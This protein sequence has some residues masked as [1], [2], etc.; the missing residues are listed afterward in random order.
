MC[1]VPKRRG[2][3]ENGHHL[4]TGVRLP[5]V[6]S[7]RSPA[8]AINPFIT[9]Q[10][11]LNQLA[12]TAIRSRSSKSLFYCAQRGRNENVPSASRDTEEEHIAYRREVYRLED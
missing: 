11:R 5:R 6:R 9:L 8:R 4:V 1:L 12:T 10:L 2:A 3:T 7:L